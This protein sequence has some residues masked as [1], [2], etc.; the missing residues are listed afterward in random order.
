MWHDTLH[1]SLKPHHTP[2][3]ESGRYINSALFGDSFTRIYMRSIIATDLI[4]GWHVCQGNIYM[5]P[6]NQLTAIID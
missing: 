1:F 5:Y 6:I 4:N 3:Q 2:H